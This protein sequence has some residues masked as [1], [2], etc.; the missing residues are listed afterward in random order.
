MKYLSTILIMHSARVLMNLGG[1]GEFW[2]TF[3]GEVL[4][5]TLLLLLKRGGGSEGDQR[6]SLTWRSQVARPGGGRMDPK[7][8][9]PTTAVTKEP[10]QTVSFSSL[11]SHHKGDERKGERVT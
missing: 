10:G 8:Y 3:A 6:V 1:C 4:F 9:L 5:R 2:K 11:L 7:L